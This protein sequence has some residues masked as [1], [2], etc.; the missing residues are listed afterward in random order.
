MNDRLEK[1]YVVFKTHFDIGFTGLASD[2]VHKYKTEMLK[3]VIAICDKTKDNDPN[4]KYVWT[5]S[6]WPLL[7]SL[8]GSDESDKASALKF[9]EDGQLI[10]HMLPYTTHTE[11]CGLEEWIRGMYVSRSLSEKFGYR[12][13]DAK[14][15]DVPGHTWIVPSLLK[16]AG[17]EI[18]HLGCNGFSTPPDVP[19]VFFWEGPDGERLLTFYSKGAYGTGILP[20]EEWTHPVWL[21]LIHTSDNHGPHEATVIE[22]MKA[23]IA[24]SGL[25]AELHIGSLSDFAVD[26]LSRNPDLPVI[27]GDLADAWI[28]GVGTA[29]REVSRVRELRSRIA[30]AESALALGM[31]SGET[32]D[33]GGAT[34]LTQQI[35]SKID[36]SYEYTLLFGEHTWGMDCKSFLFPRTYDKKSFLKDKSSERYLKMEHSWQEQINYL[37]KAETSLDAAV[38]MLT[39]RVNV[40]PSKDKKTYRIYNYLGWQ[41]DAFVLL[42]DIESLGSDEVF[43]D[44]AN[45]EQLIWSFT[46]SGIIVEVKQLPALGYKTIACINQVELQAAYKG[47]AVEVAATSVDTHATELKGYVNH[48]ESVLENSFVRVKL[49]NRTGWITSLY[50]KKLQK[51]WVEETSEFG[52]GQYEYNIYSSEEITRYIKKYAYRFYDWGVHDFGKTEY[53]EQQKRLSFTTELSEIRLIE[54]SDFVRLVCSASSDTSSVSEYGN[55]NETVWSITLM[56][57]SPNIDLEWRF[58]GK[59]ETPMAESGHLLFPLKLDNPSYRINKLGS[60]IDPCTD[61]V[62]SSNTLLHCCENFV[63][64]SDGNVG[65]AIIP[66]DTPLFSIG[67][68]GMWDFEPDYKPEKPEINF[69]LFN[70]WWGTNFPQWVGG[71]LSYRYR[72]IPHKGDWA[73]GSVWKQAQETMTPVSGILVGEEHSQSAIADLL[74]NGLDGMAVT[75]FKPAEDGDGYILRLREWI[76]QSREVTVHIALQASEVLKTDLLEYK[77]KENVCSL[78]ESGADNV[79]QFRFQTQPF[80]IHTFRI[81]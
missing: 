9:L 5:M 66:L 27:R 23:S 47:S 25:Q 14:M 6:A 41:R 78:I 55:A 34:G 43:I 70:N 44:C 81:R 7:Q 16:K 15:T 35:K 29:P 45:G 10:W 24:E 61:I 79:N 71:S 57:D 13:K 69:N 32:S 40:T 30:A 56:E 65:M 75:S 73:E 62:R 67:R 1:I 53:P 76:G 37:N 17:V 80:E 54:E 68:N 36:E 11:F 3:E 8:Q 59:E 18:L 19:P 2:V 39:G 51:E 77:I 33:I 4:E 20:P 38:G 28:H 46:N 49:D 64:V 50:D 26:F 48:Q 52:F 22:E 12:P 63:D 42:E 31:L 74:P 72:L 21:A 58:T 60:V